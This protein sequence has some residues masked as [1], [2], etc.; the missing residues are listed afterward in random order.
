ME[1][2]SQVKKRRGR[3][4]L[5]AKRVRI[6]EVAGLKGVSDS[7]LECILRNLNFS[8]GVNRDSVRRTYKAEFRKYGTQLALPMADGSDDYSWSI[9][10]MDLII[11]YFARLASFFK[12][13]LEQALHTSGRDLTII[14]Y[15]D[16]YTAGNPLACDTRRKAWG[17]YVGILECGREYLCHEAAWVPVGV[18]RTAVS[19]KVLGGVS[20]CVA[21]LLRSWFCGESPRIQD[22]GI[23]LELNNKP[24]LIRLRFGRLLADGDALRGILNWKGAGG[25]KSCVMCWNCFKKDHELCDDDLDLYDITH[26]DISSFNLNT[27]EDFW[28]NTDRLAREVDVLGVG[29][30][31]NLEISTGLNYSPD[32]LL[33]DIELRE[34][35]KPADSIRYDP[36]HCLI[37]NGIANIEIC[38]FLC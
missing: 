23:A 14:A 8:G 26:C 15:L 29:A 5:A 9:A 16:E 30:F 3:S 4:N 27:N 2:S 25:I 33:A 10:R 12:S 37:A 17:C 32:G 38:F 1:N 35:F 20:Q 21:R 19:N 7:A 24:E 18:L 22:H 11:P 28:E 36:M 34:H 13:A 31:E 6:L